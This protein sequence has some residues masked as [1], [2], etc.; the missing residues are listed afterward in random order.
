[1]FGG[2]PMRLLEK[3][4]DGEI[5]VAISEPLMEEVRRNLRDKFGWSEARVGEAGSLIASFTQLVSP[6]QTL[7]IVK[8]DPDDNRVLECAVAAG[9]DLIVSGDLDLLQL[10]SYGTIKIVRASDLL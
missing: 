10:G 8:R 3:A 6:T 5:H 1:M 9:C 4:V 7:D 2:K